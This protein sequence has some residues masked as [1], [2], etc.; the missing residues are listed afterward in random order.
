MTVKIILMEWAQY[1]VKRTKIISGR[2]FECGLGTILENINRHNA[3]LAF[4][5]I[6]VINDAN[7]V[8][9]ESYRALAADY[10]FVQSVVFRDNSGYDFGAYDVGYE[11]LKSSAFE[12]DVV[13]MNSSVNGPHADNWLKSYYDLFHTSGQDVGVV[14]ASTGVYSPHPIDK[15]RFKRIASWPLIRRFFLKKHFLP[16]VQTYFLY[17][18]MHVLQSVFP[19]GLP[20]ANVMDDKF[21]L[22]YQ[23]EISLSQA[24]IR[25]GY[26]LCCIYYPNFFYRQGA[27]WTIYRGNMR[28]IT[29]N[30]I[31][32]GSGQNYRIIDGRR[33]SRLDATIPGPSN[34]VAR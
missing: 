32:P 9:E 10:P 3:G 27:K 8:Q 25:A 1:P 13:F 7:T 24:I 21:G 26:S 19:H 29:L 28:K 11:I 17:S 6:L 15:S 34:S 4:D 31:T 16:H 12:G 23:G 22:I 30:D 33:A 5:L 14:G 18:N 2:E 20:G